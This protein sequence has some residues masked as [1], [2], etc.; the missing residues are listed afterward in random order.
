MSRLVS[1]ARVLKE[2]FGFGGSNEAQQRG[3][4]PV[5]AGY[6]VWRSSAGPGLAA[7]FAAVLTRA[8]WVIAW[9]KLPS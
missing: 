2:E 4:E 5:T 8:M 7:R 9:G 6:A 3:G 1:T